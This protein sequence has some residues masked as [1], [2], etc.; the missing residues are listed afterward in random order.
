M[1][2]WR[3]KWTS[4]LSSSYSFCSSEEAATGDIDGGDNG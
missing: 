2:F 3:K 4:F 1:I